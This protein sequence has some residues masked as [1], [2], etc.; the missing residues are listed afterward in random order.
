MEEVD[1]EKYTTP[2]VIAERHTTP[3]RVDRSYI[4]VSHDELGG[5]SLGHGAHEIVPPSEHDDNDDRAYG[6]KNKR[7]GQFR[8][9]RIKQGKK[10]SAQAVARAM[11]HK[12]IEKH[13]H[14]IAKFHNDAMDDDPEYGK[15]KNENTLPPVYARIMENRERAKHMKGATPP[16]GMHD[17]SMS[18]KGAM[19]MLNTPKDVVDNPESEKPKDP[20]KKAPLRKGDNAQGDAMQTPKDTTKAA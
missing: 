10:T 15:K 18:S 2:L 16:E 19:D 7:T 20:S 6:H 11:G 5:G 13:H 8:A 3:L 12:K 14:V 4:G 1:L 9:V 17:K